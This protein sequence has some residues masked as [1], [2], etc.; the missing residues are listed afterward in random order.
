[1]VRKMSKTARGKSEYALQAE[2]LGTA[3]AVKQAK[4]ILGSE[5]EQQS[6]SAEIPRF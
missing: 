2:Q 5:K 3:H 1:M 4:S 6:S